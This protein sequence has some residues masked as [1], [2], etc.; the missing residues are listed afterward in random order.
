L[1]IKKYIRPTFI[2]LLILTA[3]FAI[4]LLGAG[5]HGNISMKNKQTIS[6]IYGGIAFVLSAIVNLI[7]MQKK[8]SIFMGLMSFALNLI[9]G[10]ILTYYLVF[11]IQFNIDGGN[12][13][14]FLLIIIG[15]EI[16]MSGIIIRTDLKQLNKN[17]LQ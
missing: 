6:I 4:A 9:S 11:L 16:L 13:P 10:L 12:F 2:I 7:S 14:I 5:S 3:F 15:L 1:N 17:W 8:Y